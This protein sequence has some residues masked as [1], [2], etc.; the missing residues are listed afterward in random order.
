MA[1]ILAAARWAPSGD[2]TQPWRFEVLDGDTVRIHVQTEA[3]QNPYEYRD[4]EPSLLSGGMLLENLRL[5]ATSHGRRLTW[6]LEGGA[7]PYQ[8]LVRLHPAPDVTEDPLASVLALRSVDRRPYLSRPLRPHERAALEAAAGPDLDVRWHEARR[9]R[10]DLARLGMAATDIRL[11]AQETFRVHQAVIDWAPGNSATGLP[12][13]ALGLDRLTLRTMR[14]AMAHWPR[15]H[16]MNRLAGT[17]A[18]AAQLDVRPGLGSAAFF[19]L[20]PGAARDGEDRVARLLRL[21]GAVQRFWLT[22]ARL[23]LAMQP[24]LATLIFSHYGAHSLPFT[25][26]PALQDKA[27]K[28][29]T[30]FQAVLGAHPD[31]M[32]FLGRIGEPRTRLPGVRSVRQDITTLMQH[33]AAGTREQADARIEA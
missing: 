23:G 26:D 2:N 13:G 8:I 19:T 6:T 10:L 24:G 9:Q 21:G 22:A 3:G 33:P 11:R 18:A 28:L 17:W 29:A 1:A 7:D 4:G 14:W 12:A 20:S 25:A 30:R 15:M 16:A 27:A 31:S 32:V 5:A